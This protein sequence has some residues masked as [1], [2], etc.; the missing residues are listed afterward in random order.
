MAGTFFVKWDVPAF[1]NIRTVRGACCPLFLQVPGEP[2]PIQ[3]DHLV[4]YLIP[5][6]I[7]LGPFFDHISTGKIQH[8]FQCTVT[9]KYTF[10]LCHF[11]VLAVQSFYDVCGVHDTPDII[12][13][14]EE[15]ADIVPVI[16]P[17][18]YRI[19]IFSSPFFFNLFQF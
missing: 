10:C 16:L 17:V 1:F 2:L 15:G 11:P 3:D 7:P 13:E 5:V 18:A 19:G 12:R 9:G 14:L 6:P 8:L 4:Q